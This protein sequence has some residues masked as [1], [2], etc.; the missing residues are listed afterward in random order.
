MSIKIQSNLN[1]KL[2]HNMRCLMVDNVEKFRVVIDNK[3]V[4]GK[5]KINF[6][7]NWP[8]DG[9][10]KSFENY[11]G[12][13]EVV[14]FIPIY[15]TYSLYVFYGEGFFKKHDSWNDVF[16]KY[17]IQNL[18]DLIKNIHDLHLPIDFKGWYTAKTGGY[19]IDTLTDVQSSVKTN[20]FN[21]RDKDNLP[22]ITLYAQWN[23]PKYTIKVHN[24]TRG[25]GGFSSF[26]NKE[27]K[28][29]TTDSVTIFRNILYGTDLGTF[30]NNKISDVKYSTWAY[31]IISRNPQKFLGWSEKQY[32]Y[33]VRP[34]FINFGDKFSITRN[35]DLYP[36]FE[37][38]MVFKRVGL[39][40]GT[41]YYNR[42]QHDIFTTQ[43]GGG[44]LLKKEASNSLA[45]ASN[46]PYP[47]EVG[48]PSEF[49][50]YT[51][52]NGE[53]TGHYRYIWSIEKKDYYTPKDDD[54][55]ADPWHDISLSSTIV[56]TIKSV[57]PYWWQLEGHY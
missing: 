26:Y 17:N 25:Q 33:Q 34:Y 49:F 18:S 19:K 4:Y 36:H 45:I 1:D 51:K 30:L 24:I 35:M 46:S 31:N 42:Y 57:K 47:E 2:L 38:L 32:E 27:T 39:P 43:T 28:K 56:Y 48:H 5:G 3:I 50:R 54:S 13:W 7:F 55:S 53:Y 12:G 9:S 44:Y 29:T 23:V 15:P 11:Y 52:S 41:F 14:R 8:K 6:D 40:S 16:Y 21:Y 22:E 37:I 20:L 10:G